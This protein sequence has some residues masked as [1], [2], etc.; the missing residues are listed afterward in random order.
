MEFFIAKKN[1]NKKDLPSNFNLIQ[2]SVNLR[3]LAKYKKKKIF[4]LSL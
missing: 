1:G 4:I 3:I 2:A